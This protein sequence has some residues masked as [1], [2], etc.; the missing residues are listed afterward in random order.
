MIQGI[1]FAGQPNGKPRDNTRVPNK[2]V[3]NADRYQGSEYA[4]SED[5]TTEGARR[6]RTIEAA[7]KRGDVV[8]LVGRT[9]YINGKPAV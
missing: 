2:P 7:R 8:R 1:Y 6:L 9:W 3:R 5:V 4:I